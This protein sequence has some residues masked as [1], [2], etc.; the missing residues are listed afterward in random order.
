MG[1]I[2]RDQNHHSYS[3]IKSQEIYQTRSKHYKQALIQSQRKMIPTR[4][5]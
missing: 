4:V 3:Q 1:A 2:P 5:E